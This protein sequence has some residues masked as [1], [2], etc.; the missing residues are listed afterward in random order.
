MKGT[1]GQSCSP[2]TTTFSLSQNN[3]LCDVMQQLYASEIFS[4]SEL[5][6]S[7]AIVNTWRRT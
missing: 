1:H 4:E 5:G 3:G 6:D 7:I 2:G